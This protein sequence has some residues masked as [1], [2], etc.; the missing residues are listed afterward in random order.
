MNA[1]KNATLRTSSFI[2]EESALQ[3]IFCEGSAR[4]KGR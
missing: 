3:C 1:N 4:L 2:Y